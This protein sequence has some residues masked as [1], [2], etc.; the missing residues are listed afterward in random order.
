LHG[1]SSC[2][3]GPRPPRLDG[4]GA[5][6]PVAFCRAGTVRADAPVVRWPGLVQPGP[7]QH[8]PQD[9]DRAYDVDDRVHVSLPSRWRDAIHRVVLPRA[10]CRAGHPKP[11]TYHVPTPAPPVSLRPEHRSST[12]ICNNR[13]IPRVAELDAVFAL[14]NRRVSGAA[15]GEVPRRRG[16]KPPEI[17]ERLRVVGG[18]RGTAEAREACVSERP[19][20]NLRDS[21]MFLPFSSGSPG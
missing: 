9:D 11:G 2:Q 7:T 16:R 4:C 6:R 8:H 1:L 13:S 5:P 15:A 21:P 3:S 12:W 18:G 14:T 10:S 20:R 19:E 17:S